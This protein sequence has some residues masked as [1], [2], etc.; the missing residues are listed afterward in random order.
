MSV[1]ANESETRSHLVAFFKI[2]SH[3]GIIMMPLAF[4]FPKITKYAEF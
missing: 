4:S 3:S 1:L 2:W